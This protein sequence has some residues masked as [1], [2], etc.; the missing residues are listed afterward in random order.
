MDYQGF[1]L[2]MSAY[3]G[4]D[5]SEDMCKHLFYAFHKQV[6]VASLHATSVSLGMSQTILDSMA[7]TTPQTDMNTKHC[8]ARRGKFNMLL[9]NNSR[10]PGIAESH[11]MVIK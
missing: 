9:F 2:F 8:E 10:L 11:I 4:D 1:K 5:V 3:L 6:P 7:A